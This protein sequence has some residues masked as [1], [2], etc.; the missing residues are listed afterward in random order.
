MY[1]FRHTPEPWNESITDM[2]FSIGSYKFVG[3]RSTCARLQMLT[4]KVG[5]K[6][7]VV[8]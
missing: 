2:D 1:T 7:L 6:D 5:P 8:K 4:N 3:E